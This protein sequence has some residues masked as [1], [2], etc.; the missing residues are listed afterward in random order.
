MNEINLC[1]ALGL[2]APKVLR[3]LCLPLTFCSRLW[4]LPEMPFLLH[5]ANTPLSLTRHQH[6]PHLVWFLFFHLCAPTPTQARE[7]GFEDLPSVPVTLSFV[8]ALERVSVCEQLEDR[9]RCQC[10]PLCPAP[11]GLSP[12][13]DRWGGG[14]QRGREKGEGQKGSG[15]ERK[16]PSFFPA[17][18][19]PPPT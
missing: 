3:M 2:T 10:I 7:P 14:G 5:L 18:H 9:D 19:I 13:R 6:P 1:F 4:L 16:G 11:P 12:S 15:E 17:Y 8:T